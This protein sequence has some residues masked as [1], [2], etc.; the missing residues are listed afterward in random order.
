MGEN[1]TSL[2]V[3]TRWILL[4]VLV[5]SVFLG[6]SL[7]SSTP[8]GIVFLGFLLLLI[9][10]LSHVLLAE[11]FSLLFKLLVI[12][13]VIRTLVLF[14]VD[15]HVGGLPNNRL[16]FPDARGY[17]FSAAFIARLW[18]QG[19]PADVKFFARGAATGYYYFV[20]AIYYV[21]GHSIFLARLCNAFLGA[22]AV[23]YVY[24]VGKEIFD[25]ETARLGAW[26]ACLSPG[27]VWWS[28]CLLKDTFVS[29]LLLASYYHLVKARH[30]PIHLLV[31]FAASF[32]LLVTRFYLFGL[33]WLLGGIWYVCSLGKLRRLH[34]VLG[35][36]VLC[37]VLTLAL[38]I[39][40]E[41]E[42]V[43]KLPEFLRFLNVGGSRDSTS[44]VARYALE[45][46]EQILAFLPI[47][48]VRFLFG[49]VLWKLEGIYQVLLPSILMRYVLLPFFLVA[50][51]KSLSTFR[52]P[53]WLAGALIVALLIVY[54]VV[55]RGSAA[56]RYVQLLGF[57]FLF[58]A[59]ELRSLGFRDLK[60][61][62]LYVAM[63]AGAMV[64]LVG[65]R[66][67]GILILLLACSCGLLI[68]LPKL[69]F[70]KRIRLRAAGE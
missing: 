48:I 14:W 2:D 25:E 34:V 58:S 8:V 57:I 20:S 1:T 41:F 23:I 3:S 47:G 43:L 31:S 30:A 54:A 61:V 64:F 9:L 35:L 24:L 49:P 68:L 69:Q 13:F 11:S 33:F 50:L 66:E 15:W 26:L 63:L 37:V 62:V 56:R 22:V 59:N 10:L 38:S 40:F 28:T 67:F 36:A 45:G 17:D 5:Q 12:A 44:F 60:V 42:H 52:S 7:F 27:L 46:W 29:L 39:A 21:F 18:E 16:F 65:L 32:L 4:A 19:E 70:T 55:F 51:V 6:L 53:R